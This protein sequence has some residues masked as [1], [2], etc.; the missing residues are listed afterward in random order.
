MMQI[1]NQQKTRIW[2]RDAAEQEA[3]E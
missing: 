1:M 3:G 2:K